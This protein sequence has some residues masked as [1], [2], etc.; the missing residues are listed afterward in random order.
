MCRGRCTWDIS[1][2][3]AQLCGEAKTAQKDEEGEREGEE[4]EE[5]EEERGEGEGEED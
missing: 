4:K 1:I 3:P 5:E 2:P